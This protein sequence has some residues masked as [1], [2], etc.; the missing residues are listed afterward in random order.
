MSRAKQ[1][2]HRLMLCMPDELVRDIDTWRRRQNDK[3]TRSEAIRRMIVSGLKTE[4]K[5]TNER[6]RER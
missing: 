2:E 3:P 4:G 6:N 5:Q 1:F